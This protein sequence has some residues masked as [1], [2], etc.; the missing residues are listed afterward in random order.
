[1]DLSALAKQVSRLSLGKR[2]PEAVY[3]HSYA[4]PHVPA[5]LRDAVAAAVSIAKLDAGAFDVIKF[6]RRGA[7]VSLLRYPDFFADPF[8][9]LADSWLVDLGQPLPPVAARCRRRRS[10]S[11]R[12]VRGISQARRG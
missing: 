9:C 4:L 12:S 8:P 3:I 5:E 2:L 1:M 10:R 7:N 6:A 11:A